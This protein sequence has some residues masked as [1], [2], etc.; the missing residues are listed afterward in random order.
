MPKITLLM[1]TI[2]ALGIILSTSLILYLENLRF[3]RLLADNLQSISTA[4]A[5]SVDAALSF[6]LPEDAAQALASLLRNQQIKG[7]TV[8]R[9]DGAVF[10]YRGDLALTSL[11]APGTS[12]AP[13]R[14]QH[15]QPIIKGADTVGYVA[16]VQSLELYRIEEQRFIR[17]AGASVLLSL[18]VCILASLWLQQWISSPVRALANL[19]SKISRDND[20]TRRAAVVTQDEIGSLCQ[21][22]NYMLEQVD[23]RTQQLAHTTSLLRLLEAVSRTA[24]QAASPQDA[25]EQV[26]GLICKEIDW[27]YGHV[28]V[29]DPDQ[30]DQLVSS[31]I[32]VSSPALRPLQELTLKMRCQSGHGLAG[33]VLAR[34]SCVRLETL[35]AGTLQE[36]FRLAAKLGVQNGFAFPVAVD[37]QVLAVLEFLGDKGEPPSDAL[38]E[39]VREVGRQIARVFERERTGSQLVAAMQEAERANNTKS[40]FLAT[41]SHEIRTPLNAVLGMAGLL[42]DTPLTGEQREYARTIRSSGEGLLGI[43]NDILDFSKIEAGRLDLEKVPF[44]LIECVEGT[45]DLVVGLA[46]K[47]KIDLAYR[48]GS[49]VPGIIVGDSTRLR[50]ILLNLLS[51][52]IKFTHRGEVEVTL[53]RTDFS[54]DQH[55]IHFAVRDTGVG[56]PP[57]RIG[58]LFSPFTQADSSVTRKYGG[59]GLGLAISKRFAEAMGGEVWITSE[60][61]VGSVFHFTIRVPGES[62]PERR[63]AQ[64]AERFLGRRVL[65][66]DDNQTNRQIMRLQCESW[67]MSV[68]ATESPTQA[69]EWIEAGQTFDLGVLDIVMPE[70][71]GVTL[72]RKIRERSHLPLVAWTALG[73][74][75][76]GSEDLFKASMPKPLRPSLFFDVLLAVFENRSRLV[77]VH[78]PTFDKNLGK[79]YPLRILV[80]DDVSVNQRMMLLMLEKLG[81][82]SEAAGNGLEV[83]Q[84]MQHATYDVILMDVNMPEMDGLEATRQIHKI[85]GETRPRI[86][87][88][89]ANVT[90]PEREGCLAAGMDDFLAKPIVTEHLREALIRAGE[91]KAVHRPDVDDPASTQPVGPL[92]YAETP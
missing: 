53:E 58:S 84:M 23:H 89:T 18:I 40:S 62:G 87:A 4:L 6:E 48:V 16:V 82:E 25:L 14:V 85:Y 13:D 44:D 49:E 74:P 21:S 51:N 77:A 56:I 34:G 59:T 35:G 22:F 38:L 3:H 81:Y 12:F 27:P 67:G 80:A 42:L 24:N 47:K 10:V 33:S 63:Y 26:V 2:T 90:Q 19:A 31:Q 61:G 28:W 71:D 52:A 5:E 64:A 79:R 66:V 73:R 7:A 45:M 69:L 60:V 32:F 39:A 1:G 65:V 86:V 57:D 83:L 72:A 20:Y 75:E 54:E 46:A 68:A 55:L 41:M 78:D 17:L 70:M 9:P 76:A 37:Q 8:F 88:L 29:P 91:W 43:I 36:R 30:P 15:T 92:E 50:Q 11:P